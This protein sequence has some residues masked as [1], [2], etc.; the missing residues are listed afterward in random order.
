MLTSR[1]EQFGPYWVSLRV[2]W[3]RVSCE[4]GVFGESFRDSEWMPM[5]FPFYTR[6]EHACPN[7][8]HCPHPGGAALR[9][10]VLRANGAAETLNWLVKVRAPATCPHCPGDVS[11]VSGLDPVDRLQEDIIENVHPAAC[12]RHEAAC[13]DDCRRPIQQAV[14]DDLLDS[15]IGPYLR[16]RAVWLRNAIGISYR[17]ISRIIEEMHHLHTPCA[18]RV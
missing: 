12:Y 8:G 11:A 13:S 16:S 17:K 18:D 6:H 3:G 10:L 2:D 7:V 14:R 4:L 15:R 9:T 5:Q 1:E